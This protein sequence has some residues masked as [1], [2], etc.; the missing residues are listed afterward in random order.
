MTARWTKGIKVL[1]IEET[2]A[3]EFKSG[4][5]VTVQVL[6]RTTG[7]FDTFRSNNVEADMGA[8]IYDTNDL[9]DKW[10]LPYAITLV[11]DHGNSEL[12]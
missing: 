12:P 9:H 11:P 1:T 6:L 4:E 3:H 8:S 10:T 5:A 7:D 2:L